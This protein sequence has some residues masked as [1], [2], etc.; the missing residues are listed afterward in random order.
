MEQLKADAA[1]F[2]RICGG[3][4]TEVEILTDR[5]KRAYTQNIHNTSKTTIYIDGG[6]SRGT[7]WHE[8]GHNLEYDPLAAKL[9]TA[10]LHRRRESSTL[11]RLSELTG[12]RGYRKDEVAYKDHFITPYIGKYYSN[13]STE[14]FSMGLEYLSDPIPASMMFTKDREMAELV[15]G[16]LAKQKSE[17]YDFILQREAAAFEAIRKED[18]ANEA[19][20]KAKDAAAEFE[21]DQEPPSAAW[22]EK[23]KANM[24][25]NRRYHC[26]K[27]SK[28]ELIGTYSAGGGK[29][30]ALEY[31]SGWNSYIG[32][33]IKY[34]PMF[35]VAEF[36]SCNNTY[37]EDNHL[38]KNKSDAIDYFKELAN[39]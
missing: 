12:S 15:T 9:A 6:F 3:R 38:F 31:Y 29:F 5:S 10:F 17:L 7:L 2:Y 34:V 27:N 23:L 14:V 1:A 19:K 39:A 11:Y 35:V 33:K 13:G 32:K 37:A 8:M 4:L 20:Q 25:R 21:F 22:A 26:R 28:Y 24:E 36:G 18:E 30:Y 16:Y